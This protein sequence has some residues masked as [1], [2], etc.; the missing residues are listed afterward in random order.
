MKKIFKNPL[1]TFILGAIIFG[2]I[3]TVFAYS[4]F[5]NDVDFSPK[6]IHWNVGNV[7]DALDDL[8]NTTT[9]YV[10]G[11]ITTSS[12]ST[13]LQI[14][15]GFE[16]RAVIGIIPTSGDYLGA[17]AYIKD[18]SFVGYAK[19]NPKLYT[20]SADS[21]VQT[22]ATGFKWHTFDS[23]WKTQTIYYYAFK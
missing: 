18:K 21:T 7:S 6:D 2:T 22:Y 12:Y 8:R 20:H 16:P 11:T 17:F 13:W 4:T 5:A 15:T 9:D 14:E 23:T 1:F 19:G 3:S 10:Y